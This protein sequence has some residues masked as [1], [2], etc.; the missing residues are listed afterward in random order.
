MKQTHLGGRAEQFLTPGP[1]FT[2]VS[3]SVRQPVSEQVLPIGDTLNIHPAQAGSCPLKRATCC[4]TKIM[5]DERY[6]ETPPPK[7]KTIKQR[8]MQKL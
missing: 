5:T 6:V 2:T 3:R 7:M 4:P 8:I 1:A